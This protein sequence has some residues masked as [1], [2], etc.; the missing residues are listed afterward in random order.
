MKIHHFLVKGDLPK[1]L[2]KY[3]DHQFSSGGTTG[4]DYKAFEAS[5]GRWLKKTLAGYKV[6]IH[7]NHYEFS[8]V[9]TRKGAD[10]APDRYVY[11][12][13]S[14]VRFFD[15]EWVYHIMVRQ[16]RHPTDWCG[17]RNH[18]CQIDQIKQFVDELMDMELE[19]G[20]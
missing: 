19:P 16:M 10:G 2:Q 13:I 3:W 15:K 18:Y 4:P 17:C 8:A 5:Y 7:G 20:I 1:P 11:L 12:S 14:D 9:V 6:E